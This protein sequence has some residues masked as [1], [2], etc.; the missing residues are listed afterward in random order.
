[1][2][3]F[4]QLVTNGLSHSYHLDDLTLFLGASG[5]I[6]HF[7]FIFDK[8]HLSKQNSPRWDAA[9]CR[10]SVCICLI[11]RTPGLYGLMEFLLRKYTK[12]KPSS[13][14]KSYGIRTS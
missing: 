13:G 12:A 10:Y 5:V 14:T 2:P 9:F 8:I 4:N 3:A 6:F 7:Y 11:K 1:M